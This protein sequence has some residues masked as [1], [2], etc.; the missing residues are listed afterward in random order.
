MTQ[1]T[2][3]MKQGLTM[4]K[5]ITNQM[6]YMYSIMTNTMKTN[7]LLRPI[8]KWC[9][10]RFWLKEESCFLNRSR[11][12][13]YTYLALFLFIRSRSLKNKAKME[14]LKLA[15]KDEIIATA[16]QLSKRS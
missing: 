12:R 16:I 7:V 1:A 15:S 4:F 9:E 8:Y 6:S 5:T 2:V 10:T 11:A 3:L 13:I 14:E